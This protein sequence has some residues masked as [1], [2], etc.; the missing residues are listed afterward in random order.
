VTPAE[1]ARTTAALSHIGGILDTL[2]IADYLEHL[3]RER[4]V[5]P[6]AWER[7]ALTPYQSAIRR[8]LQALIAAGTKALE[9]VDEVHTASA[10][11]AQ[12]RAIQRE[13]AEP[14]AAATTL[15]GTVLRFPSAERIAAKLEG[16]TCPMGECSHRVGLDGPA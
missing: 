10:F 13:E 1:V 14:P 12:A 9:I 7:E 5:L 4:D 6:H 8:R 3:R 2:P 11:G 15:V 16:C